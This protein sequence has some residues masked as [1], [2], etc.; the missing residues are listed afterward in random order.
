MP[1][2]EDENQE[3][4]F[5]KKYREAEEKLKNSQRRL[6]RQFTFDNEE[7]IEL[8]KRLTSVAENLENEDDDESDKSSGLN[9][10]NSD[11]E[12]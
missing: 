1:D 6:S 3:D 5:S 11:Q 9:T 2:I 7:A 10:S 12:E 4:F 8:A